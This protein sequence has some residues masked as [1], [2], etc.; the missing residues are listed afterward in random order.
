MQQERQKEQLAHSI[1]YERVEPPPPRNQ[2][3]SGHRGAPSRSVFTLE[4]CSGSGRLTACLI[5]IGFDGQAVDHSKN[6]HRKL[7][8]TLNLDLTLDSSWEV[9]DRLRRENRIFFMHAAPP[10]GTATRARERPV[11]QF[12]RKQGA[13][14]PRPLRT[15]DEPLGVADLEGIDKIKVDAANKIYL[16]LASFA[17]DCHASGVKISIENPRRSLLWAIRQFK[18]LAALP[19]MQFVEFQH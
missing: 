6:R 12:L 15:D 1:V 17:S 11:P 16:K 3:T 5:R 13:P 18:R 4:L 2:P 8:A 14:N 9:L 10:C 19:G 7:T